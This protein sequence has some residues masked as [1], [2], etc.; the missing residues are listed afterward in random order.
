MG[1]GST[2]P[3][4]GRMSSQINLNLD[5][6]PT[7]VLRRV[8]SSSIDFLGLPAH[9]AMGWAVGG[10]ARFA[11][12]QP[13]A[14]EISVGPTPGAGMHH[15]PSVTNPTRI[16]AQAPLIG[17]VSYRLQSQG[18]PR[19]ISYRALKT[20]TGNCARRR[21]RVH[22]SPQPTLVI[23]NQW[24]QPISRNSR[25]PRSGPG[26]LRSGVPGNAPCR[27]RSLRFR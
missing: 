14:C 26:F 1:N 19:A 5:G 24:L 18:A 13:F 12:T 9:V 22:F 10:T 25:P 15:L 6:G 17:V 21:K 7:A 27:I 8:P 11:R 23:R 20:L 4:A 3:W 16:V 2:R